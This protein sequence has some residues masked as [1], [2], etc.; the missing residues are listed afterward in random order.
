MY[1]DNNTLTGYLGEHPNLTL[2]C[3]A[4]VDER[5][6]FLFLRLMRELKRLSQA[7][8]QIHV[9]YIDI[10]KRTGVPTPQVE[11]IG[12]APSEFELLCD[13]YELL[14]KLALIS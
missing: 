14:Y 9:F 10:D 12:Q 3:S 13:R 4:E 7:D 5:Y 1:I 2:S 11:V 8:A 6:T